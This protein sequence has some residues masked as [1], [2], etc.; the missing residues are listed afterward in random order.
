[1]T[2]RAAIPRSWLDFLKS[3][4]L[5]VGLDLATTDGPHSNPASITVMEEHGGLFYERLIL[6]WKTRDEA[7]T[8]QMLRCVLEDLDS[9]HRRP[10]RVCIDAS[11]E[12][13]FAQSLAKELR[14]LA[15]FTLIKGS[16]NLT[17]QGETLKS[18]ELLGNLFTNLHAEGRIATPEGPWIKEDRRLV[19]K[20]KGQFITLTGKTGEHGDTFDSGKLAR[21]ALLSGGPIEAAAASVGTNP[22]GANNRN[23]YDDDDEAEDDRAGFGRALGLHHLNA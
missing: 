1:M 13:F 19:Q 12:T 14:H 5:G 11:N 21:W 20:S 17:F 23:P 22:A 16:E 15:A 7:V 18:K 8:R 10:R 3:G 6:A 4:P 2:P 9:L